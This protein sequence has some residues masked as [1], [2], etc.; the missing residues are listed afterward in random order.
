VAL[1]VLKVRSERK[2]LRVFKDLLDQLELLL[3]VHLAY[4]VFKVFRDQPVHQTLLGFKVLKAHKVHKDH[5]DFKV[6][7]VLQV[8][9]VFKELLRLLQRLTYLH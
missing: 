2:G 3:Q 9:L 1:K 6:Q 7:Q 8:Q 4:Q 5:K